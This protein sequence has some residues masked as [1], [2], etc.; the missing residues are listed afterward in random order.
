MDRWYDGWRGLLSF[1]RHP[2][3]LCISFPLAIRYMFSQTVFSQTKPRSSCVPK[4]ELSHRHE[5][6]HDTT[7]HQTPHHTTPA[8]IDRSIEYIQN[9]ATC[10]KLVSCP[11]MLSNSAPTA[12]AHTPVLIVVQCKQRQPLGQLNMMGSEGLI[13]SSRAY[14]VRKGG[15]ER[16]LM[17]YCL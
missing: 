2:V 15:S 5:T 13:L 9:E 10:N 16:C 1:F 8:S 4:A 14:F 6:G 17:Y 7:Q 3:L 12:V 11:T